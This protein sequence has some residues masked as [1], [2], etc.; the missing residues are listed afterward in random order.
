MLEMRGA[1][2]NA[3]VQLMASRAKAEA[4][5][6]RDDTEDEPATDSEML[7]GAHWRTKAN[8]MGW[9][10]ITDLEELSEPFKSNAKSFIA[11][12]EAG[13]ANVEIS[14]TKRYIERAWLM[15]NAW[16]VAHGGAVPKDDPYGTGI[17]WD[18]G[19]KSATKQAAKEM[20]G[21]SGFNMAFDASM[22]S[23]HFSG[24]AVDITITNLPEEWTF[25][26]GDK[27]VTVKLGT[28]EAPSNT[29][30]HRA[31]DRYFNVKKLVADRPHWSDT[32]N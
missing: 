3:A 13:G 6:H 23:R 16:T 11:A 25:T 17:V 5:L 26:H 27:E 30:L 2:G 28:A 31:A 15:H 7:S 12:L 8:D 9:N 10:D 1:V 20:I 22:H 4:T 32:G 14:T 29:R 19:S 18:H 24:N 21:P